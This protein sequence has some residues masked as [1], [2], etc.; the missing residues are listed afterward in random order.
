MGQKGGQLGPNVG[1]LDDIQIS[2]VGLDESKKKLL[3]STTEV[4]Q[5]AEDTPSFLDAEGTS[6]LGGVFHKVNLNEGKKK[7]FRSKFREWGG[8]IVCATKES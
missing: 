6:V 7:E 2:F 1:G 8:P 3:L 5:I 4:D